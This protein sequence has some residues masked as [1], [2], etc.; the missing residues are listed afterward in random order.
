MIENAQAF[1]HTIKEKIKAYICSDKMG[2][3][4]VTYLQS[5]LSIYKSM[6]FICLSYKDLLELGKNHPLFLHFSINKTKKN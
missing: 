1:V 2:F 4:L 5:N 6:C 3:M